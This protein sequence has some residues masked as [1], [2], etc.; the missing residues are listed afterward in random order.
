MLP[1]KLTAPR[2]ALLPEQKVSLSQGAPGPDL[3]GL[4]GPWGFLGSTVST[5]D[6]HAPSASPL[7]ITQEAK[8]PLVGSLVQNQGA[9]QSGGTLFLMFIYS[10]FF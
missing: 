1:G 8:E 2:A 9:V 5:P 6:T 7:R 4:L 3:P 10:F